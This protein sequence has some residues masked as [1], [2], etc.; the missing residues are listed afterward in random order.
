VLTR[1]SFIK[2]GAA[3][4][5]AALIGLPKRADARDVG[6]SRCPNTPPFVQ[7]LR[8][9]A[10]AQPRSSNFDDM[11]PADHQRYDEYVPRLCYDLRV[12]Q[13]SHRYHPAL[14]ASVVWGYGGQ[15]PGLTFHQRYGEPIMC[16]IHNELPAAHV[17]FGIPDISTHLH[18][19]HSASESDGFPGDFHGPGTHRDHHFCAGFAGDDPREALGT[20]WYHD[21]R[22]DFTAQN[23][24][25]GLAGF[26]LMFDSLDTGNER[27][28]LRLP[29]GR[30]DVPLLFEDKVLDRNSQL[31]YDFFN[32]DG[33]LGDKFV[34]NGSIQPYMKVARRKYRFR[35]L[36]GGPARFYEVV[37][38]SG[39]P[40]LQIANDGNLFAAPVERQAV[41][42]AV[43]E[44][45]DVIVDFS[46]NKIGDS[47]YLYN[48]LEQSSGRGPSGILLNPGTPLVRFDV[49]R[50]PLP[51][52]DPAKDETD[53]SVLP[54][55]LRPQPSINLQEVVRTRQWVL[56]RENSI[57]TINDRIFDVNAVRATV[58]R[59]TAEIWELQNK[60]S[61]W[62]HPMHIHFEEFRILSRNGKTPPPWEQGRKDVVVVGPSETVRIFMRFRD[63]VGR[64]PMHCHNLT[65]E[66]H[67]MMLRWDIV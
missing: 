2:A 40:F 21:H 53:Y 30:F 48:R 23:V 34:V 42:F 57:W 17:G 56:N 62:S 15:V 33:L 4:P 1:R 26:F 28:G 66:D 39:Q 22:M 38:S 45:A 65:H 37:L 14:K 31:E 47:V 18:N 12:R 52:D 13:I 32:T 67:A 8:I 58:K 55:T 20:L 64:Y 7:P 5:A 44:R 41:R 43:A 24:Y 35:M 16:R 46:Q 49:D 54:S 60:S 27:T 11:V 36:S 9:P 59:G 51:S 6:R 29:S 10:V 25:R 63:F 3:A 61:G 50:D 19:A